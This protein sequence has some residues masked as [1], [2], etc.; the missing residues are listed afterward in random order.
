M[1]TLAETRKRLIKLEQQARRIGCTAVAA[2]LTEILAGIQ[3]PPPPRTELSPFGLA[4]EV[5]GDM[6]FEYRGEWF[7]SGREDKDLTEDIEAVARRIAALRDP[8]SLLFRDDRMPKPD[9][10]GMFS[11]PDLDIFCGDGNGGL[12]NP[13][14]EAVIE[15]ALL[16]T[17]GYEICTETMDDDDPAHALY[18]TSGSLSG[19][20]PEW[21]NAT[22]KLVA[23]HDTEDGA[24]AVFVRRIGTIDP[25]APEQTSLPL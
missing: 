23:R 16:A 4:V 17:L 15:S 6:V 10:Y 12:R 22:W 21:P 19:W 18:A 24:Q 3:P 2:E 1:S 13:E 20:N 25:P 5:L 14:D 11:H 8:M 9:A 7:C